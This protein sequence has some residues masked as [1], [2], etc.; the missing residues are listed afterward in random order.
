MENQNLSYNYVLGNRRSRGDW[1]KS[2]LFD[3]R[4]THDPNL[5]TNPH[6]NKEVTMW[7]F[8]RFASKTSTIAHGWVR[9]VE[10]FSFDVYN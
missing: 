5:L 6:L 2:Y 4:Q 10:N 8:V 9:Q 7:L 1:T 3:E